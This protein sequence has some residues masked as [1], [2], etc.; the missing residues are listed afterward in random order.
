MPEPRHWYVF[1]YDIFD[2]KRRGRVHRVLSSWGE[3][4]QRSVFK[5][6]CTSRELERLRFE[7]AREMESEDMLS[8]IRLCASCAGRVEHHGSASADFSDVV[9]DCIII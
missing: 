5:A 9:R 3:A 2:D 8:I 6:R 1:F 4:L 7:L